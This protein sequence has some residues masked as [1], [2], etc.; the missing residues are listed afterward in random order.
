[1]VYSTPPPAAEGV[2]GLINLIPDAA[3]DAVGLEGLVHGLYT[4]VAPVALAGKW[5]TEVKRSSVVSAGRLH[6]TFNASSFQCFF[7]Q[8]PNAHIDAVKVG[9]A[10]VIWSGRRCCLSGINGASDCCRQFR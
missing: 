4:G 7:T 1:M 5:R 10:A 9:A 2:D 3:I 8:K 6:P